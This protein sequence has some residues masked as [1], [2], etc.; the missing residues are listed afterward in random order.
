MPY[1]KHAP[2]ADQVRQSFTASLRNLKTDYLDSLLLHSPLPT[3]DKTL[4]VYRIFEDFHRAGQVG[5]CE[6][7]LDTRIRFI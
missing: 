7:P 3:F 2:L 5:P 1:D 6:T 4:S